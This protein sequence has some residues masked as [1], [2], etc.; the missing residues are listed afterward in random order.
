MYEGSVRDSAAYAKKSGTIP[1]SKISFVGTQALN[2]TEGCNSTK[3]HL[4]VINSGGG[5]IE[6]VIPTAAE[7]KRSRAVIEQI[8][9]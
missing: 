3:V 6:I 4:L 7:V 8:I 1:L 2:K 9:Q 5:T